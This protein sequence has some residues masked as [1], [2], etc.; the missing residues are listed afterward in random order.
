MHG[1]TSPV[2]HD[3]SALFAGLSQPFEA[4]RYHSLCAEAG[5]LPDDLVVTARTDRDEI[6]AVRHRELPIVGVQFHPE[7]V[8][9]PEGDRLMANFL[10]Q[11]NQ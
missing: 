10:E 4:G 11:E 8:L 1:K 7:S 3:G 9:T 5:T 6:M 2:T